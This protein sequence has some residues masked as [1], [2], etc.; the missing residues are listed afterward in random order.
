MAGDLGALVLS[1]SADIG[2]FRSDLQKASAIAGEHSQAMQKIFG[3]IE[4]AIAGITA[5]SLVLYIKGLVD[6]GEE[7]NKLSNRTGHAV[8]W[9]SQLRIAAAQNNTSFE[10]LG[11]ALGKFN[12]SMSEARDGGSKTGQ[13]MKVLGVD[14]TKGPTEAFKQFAARASLIEDAATKTA[15]F[16]D[17]LGKTGDTLIPLLG[18]LDSA[19]ESARKMGGTMSAETAANAEK[20]NDA[21]TILAATSK[22]MTLEALA[23]AVGV[24]ATMADNIAKAAEKG[25]R[26]TQVMREAIK[27]GGATVGR[28]GEAAQGLP[29]MFNVVGRGMQWAGEGAFNAMTPMARGLP[30][31]DQPVLPGLP[32]PDGNALTGALTGE[33]KRQADERKKMIDDL[34]KKGR[35]SEEKAAEE[36]FKAKEQE[37]LDQ[38]KRDKD[39][40]DARNK[41]YAEADKANFESWAKY[42]QD[43]E[44]LLNAIALANAEAKRKDNEAMLKDMEEQR[45]KQM[46]V[47]EADARKGEQAAR[48][49]GL[50]FVSAF[51][52]AIIKG[53]SLRD[54]LQGMVQDIARIAMRKTV[55]EPLGA[56]ISG[57][58]SGLF[59]GDGA[60]G[61]AAPEGVLAGTDSTMFGFA[62]GGR[63]TVGGA[64]GT[65][66]QLVAF[67]ASP[68]ERVTVETPGQQAGNGAPIQIFPDL[69][70]A[71]VETV[72][73]LYRMVRELGASIEPRALAAVSDARRRNTLKFS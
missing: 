56:G 63:F 34:L 23:P 46:A 3:G 66:S 42:M 64:G 9:L 51:E 25:E 37:Y 13:I 16:R 58:F 21:L 45:R 73:A 59:K 48:E 50:T 38:G 40:L 30:G 54:V 1:L 6:M 17:V 67:K 68:N 31:W 47:I 20:L 14:I 19:T 61:S 69:R 65:D 28:F 71:S 27:L 49:L 36:R 70:G 32:A 7:T 22:A 41:L 15:V 2:T 60:P 8:E 11:S 52:D 55:T 43:Q 53:K 57:F 5:G 26:W 4:T 24:F 44:D 12:L 18:N 10:D 35:D 33:T 29:G 72:D 62:S 39:A